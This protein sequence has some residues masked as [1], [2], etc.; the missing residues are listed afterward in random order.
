MLIEMN[1]YPEYL[2]YLYKSNIVIITVFSPFVNSIFK[3]S[4]TVSKYF[5]VL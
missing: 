5:C 4:D 3:K 1:K 2:K